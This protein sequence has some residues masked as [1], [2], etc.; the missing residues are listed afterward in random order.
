MSTAPPSPEH[1]LGGGCLCGGVRFEITAPFAVALYCH[2]THCQRRTGSSYSVGGRVQRDGFRLIAGRELIASFTPEGGIPK[3]FCS[4]C[5]GHVFTGDPCT[6]ALVGV[7]FGA[8]DA[9][10]GIRPTLRQFTA[11]APFWDPIPDDGLPRFPRAAP[12]G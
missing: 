11:S 12:P 10:P 8:L 4:R 6:D 1:P 3:L 2:C 7:R 5:G 9:D